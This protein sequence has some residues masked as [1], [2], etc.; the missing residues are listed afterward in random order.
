VQRMCA[1]LDEIIAGYGKQQYLSVL[2]EMADPIMT[3]SACALGKTAPTPV[4]STLKHFKA[5]YK[6][7]LS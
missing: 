4:L 7:Y 6:K 5:D 2:T 3:A 1:L